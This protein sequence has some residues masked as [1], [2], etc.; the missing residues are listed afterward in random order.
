MLGCRRCSVVLILYIALMTTHLW[1]IVS[2]KESL[3]V[4][5]IYAYKLK[6]R[7]IWDIPL[8][9]EMSW[10]WRKI[11]QLREIVRPYF[12]VK[13]GNGKNTSLWFDSWCSLCPLSQFLTVRDITREGFSLYYIVADLEANGDWMWPNSWLQKA[14]MIATIPA[15]KLDDTCLDLIKWRDL[16][17]TLNDFYVKRAWE[18]IRTRGN[19]VT[20][21]QVV[22]FNHNIPRH[23]FH[24]WLIMRRSLKTQER[25]RQWDVGPNVDLDLLVCPLCELQKDSHEHL[26]FECSFSAQVWC[27]VR[28]LAVMDQVQ[29]VLHDVLNFLQPMANRRTTTSIIGRLV[30]AAASYYIWLE[31][32]SCLFKKVKK[33]P[34][35]ITDIIMVMV[36]LKLL[37]FKFKNMAKMNQILSKWKMPTSFR[38]YG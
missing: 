26:F 22:W 25:L 21:H 17:G 32:N 15:T 6:G 30:F 12:W 36:R 3:W 34:D 19:L 9:D 7:S 1:N 33:L 35:E 4:R 28:H 2:N 13:L 18:A 10:G 24:L 31:R 38:L 23:A 5:W 14:P 29:P 11:L 27:R 16:N 37:T 20:W 8:K